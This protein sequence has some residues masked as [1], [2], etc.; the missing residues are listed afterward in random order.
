MSSESI[1]KPGNVPGELRIARMPT[2]P[3][4]ESANQSAIGSQLNSASI[5]DAGLRLRLVGARS[6]NSTLVALVKDHPIYNWWCDIVDRLL[7]DNV[8][9]RSVANEYK[10][11]VCKLLVHLATIARAETLNAPQNIPNLYAWID[12]AICC[13]PA[14]YVKSFL[15]SCT[16][17][18]QRNQSSSVIQRRFYPALL[19]AGMTKWMPPSREELFSETTTRDPYGVQKS[20]IL[21]GW[22]EEISSWTQK[23]RQHEKPLNLNVVRSYVSIARRYLIFVA[24]RA[25]RSKRSTEQPIVDHSQICVALGN[26]PAQLI[27]DFQAVTESMHSSRQADTHCWLIANHFYPFL[28]KNNWVQSMPP[29]FKFSKLPPLERSIFDAAE[30][31]LSGLAGVNKWLQE[32]VDRGEIKRVRALDIRSHIRRYIMAAIR[33]EQ[34]EDFDKISCADQ[35]R[36]ISKLVCHFPAARVK[37]YL[38]HNSSDRSF[39]SALI[40]FYDHLNRKGLTDFTIVR[41]NRADDSRRAEVRAAKADSMP[42]E[43]RS[44]RASQIRRGKGMARKR[45]APKL[46]ARQSSKSNR[47]SGVP[48]LHDTPDPTVIGKVAE[49]FFEIKRTPRELPAHFRARPGA[50]R[51]DLLEVITARDASIHELSSGGLP[52][53]SLIRLKVSDLKL[54]ADRSFLII[55]GD[56]NPIRVLSMKEADALLHYIGLA[57]QSALQTHWAVESP[58]FLAESGESLYMRH[59]PVEPDPRS[60]HIILESELAVMNMLIAEYGI[61]FAELVRARYSSNVNRGGE[62]KFSDQILKLTND[63]VKLVSLYLSNIN[64][65]AFREVWRVDRRSIRTDFLFPAADGGPFAGWEAY[66]LLVDE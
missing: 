62:F 63:Q 23:R 8:I 31:F 17:E 2:L 56:R 38:D 26:N 35:D 29:K 6:G 14:E 52:L 47:E 7:V 46:P 49:A 42:A 1:A 27:H 54:N 36:V 15:N 12:K 30:R 9:R 11:S 10:R 21:K 34:F 5:S 58:L 44:V 51:V 57:S 32:R 24:E 13:D 28:R 33:A 39:R 18:G 61:R 45:N 55:R 64:N 59:Q 41:R 3:K 16:S 50:T 37:S 20:V 53:R 4:G 65:S 60:H 66:H 48:N 19:E 43:P 22:K 25:G 40:Q